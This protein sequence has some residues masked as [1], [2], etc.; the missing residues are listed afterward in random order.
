[1]SCGWYREEHAGAFAGGSGDW[2]STDINA[3][4]EETL[5]PA[6]HGARAQDQ[7]FNITLE[8]EFDPTSRR[9]SWCRRT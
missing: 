9:L 4:A 7:N 3:L 2:Q 5:N 1:M 8:R 6:Y